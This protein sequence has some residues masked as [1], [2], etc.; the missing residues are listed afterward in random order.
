MSERRYGQWAGSPR[1]HAEDPTRCVEGVWVHFRGMLESQ[2]GRKRGHGPNGEY[3]KQHAKKHEENATTTA[4]PASKDT[5]NTNAHTPES[6]HE[7]MKSD[8]VIHNVAPVLEE[9]E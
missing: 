2:C 3:C 9:G 8:A 6:K 5:N 4:T 1:G 7:A